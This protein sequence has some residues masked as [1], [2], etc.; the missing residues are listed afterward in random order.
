MPES[1]RADFLG[2]RL[3]FSLKGGLRRRFEDSEE[4]L[5]LVVRGP[6]CGAATTSGG[7]DGSQIGLGHLELRLEL[8]HPFE[9]PRRPLFCLDS[10]GPVLLG[11]AAEVLRAGDGF[12]GFPPELDHALNDG[13]PQ[14]SIGG[15]PVARR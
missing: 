1:L 14:V 8:L 7:K 9:Q 2:L 4:R 12:S 11:L 6:G 5:H 15:A 3:R 13:A 10:S